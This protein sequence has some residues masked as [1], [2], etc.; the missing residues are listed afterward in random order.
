MQESINQA[1][2][3]LVR[4][5]HTI[6]EPVHLIS[7][8]IHREITPELDRELAHAVEAAILAAVKTFAAA[9]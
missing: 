4:I 8:F 3:M 7:A 1:G 6:S 2:I 9:V 5:E